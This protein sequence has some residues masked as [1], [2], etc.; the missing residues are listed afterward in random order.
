MSEQQYLISGKERHSNGSNWRL[1]VGGGWM[2][3]LDGGVDDVQVGDLIAAEVEDRE[4]NGRTFRVLRNV[5][6][7][8]RAATDAADQQRPWADG[9]GS[10]RTVAPVALSEQFAERLALAVAASA[11][12]A[13]RAETVEALERWVRDALSVAAEVRR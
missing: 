8:R 4:H 6:L 9:G 11:V 7:V 3:A 5:R 10:V 13:G 1:K 12:R 2:T